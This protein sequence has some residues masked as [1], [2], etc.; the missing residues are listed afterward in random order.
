MAYHMFFFSSEST[1][2]AILLQKTVG[3][4]Y[5][6]D[7]CITAPQN[8]YRRAWDFL[9]RFL[10]KTFE[11]TCQLPLS[12]STISIFVTYLFPKSFKTSTLSTYILVLEYLH[13]I[14]GLH[15]STHTFLVDTFVKLYYYLNFL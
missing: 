14:L 2:C 4:Y 6:T 1:M 9:K 5:N 15:E 3:Q 13:K 8:T 10:K 12:T 7:T 11:N